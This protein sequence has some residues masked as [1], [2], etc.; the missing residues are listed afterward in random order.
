[1]RLGLSSYCFRY[2]TLTKKPPLTS[3]EILQTAAELSADMVQFCDNTPLHT[4]NAAA[5][6][7]LMAASRSL[8]V[9]IEVGTTGLDLIHLR[10]YV[11]I[12]QQCNSRALRL[13][14]ASSDI[15]LIA[16]TLQSLAPA[17]QQAGIVLAIENHADLPS[18]TLA[19]LLNDLG[20]S[21][22][23][24]CIDTANNTNL[25]ERPVDT[26]A[27]LASRAA[28]VHL[29]DYTIEPV[30][31]GHHITGRI[32]G[33]GRLDVPVV[34]DQL[35]PRRDALDYYIELWMDPAQDLAATLAKEE[36]WIAASLS[37]ART[38]LAS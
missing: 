14:L 21:A 4:L 28:Q 26:V 30:A 33:Q 20:D 27:A 12:A 3:V 24:F 31:I 5:L 18:E 36:Q 22:L 37:A 2:A 13:V 32:L 8:D 1:M 6:D 7:D 15:D 38:Y 23:C 34:L 10:Q 25:L 17:L 19:A 16:E 9:A 29:K 35:G 11:A